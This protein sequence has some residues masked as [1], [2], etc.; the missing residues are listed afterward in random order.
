VTRKFQAQM[1]QAV[2]PRGIR[3]K[4]DSAREHGRSAVPRVQPKRVLLRGRSDKTGHLR[5]CRHVKA[6]SHLP[7]GRKRGR[8]TRKLGR[9]F[10]R[11]EPFDGNPSRTRKPGAE[12]R[13]ARMQICFAICAQT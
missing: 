7:R 9:Y 13:L 12:S 11:R 5:G 2:H 8:E 10:A 1:R 4:R 6:C 3:H